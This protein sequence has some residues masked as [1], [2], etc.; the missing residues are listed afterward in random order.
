MIK[1]F[2]SGVLMGM[3]APD[4]P[5]IKLGSFPKTSQISIV[6]SDISF[7]VSLLSVDPSIFPIMT[8]PPGK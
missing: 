8:C 3:S 4:D 1:I 2:S 7:V 5:K 6:L